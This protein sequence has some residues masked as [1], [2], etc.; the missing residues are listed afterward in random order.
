ME[1]RFLTAHYVEQIYSLDETLNIKKIKHVNEE[2]I[3]R[4][5]RRVFW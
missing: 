3:C 2:Q 5:L 1:Q 4:I